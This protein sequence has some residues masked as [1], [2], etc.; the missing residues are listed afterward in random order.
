MAPTKF[1]WGLLGPFLV[2]T[3]DFGAIECTDSIILT[4]N[5]FLVLV[6][7][8]IENSLKST[9]RSM[10]NYQR[11]KERKE[12]RLLLNPGRFPA[13]DSAGQRSKRG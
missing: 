3:A 5:Q 11:T 8:T 7:V 4:K 2:F 12:K 1:C 6:L 13:A 9:C 10:I